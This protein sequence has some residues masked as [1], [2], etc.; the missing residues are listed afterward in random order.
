MIVHMSKDKKVRDGRI[1][2]ILP[3]RIGEVFVMKEAPLDRLR[4][5]L[6]ET[7]A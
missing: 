4:D 3:R 1:A 6:A 2:L 5:F 7:A